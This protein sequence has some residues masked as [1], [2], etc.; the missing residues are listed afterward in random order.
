MPGKEEGIQTPWMLM[1]FKFYLL[2]KKRKGNC[3]RKG[4]AASARNK[5][6]SHKIASRRNRT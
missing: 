4:S 5:D 3:T 2:S 1:W 6:T